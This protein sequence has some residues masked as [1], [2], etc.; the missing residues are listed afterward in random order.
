MRNQVAKPTHLNRIQWLAIGEGT[1]RACF[2]RGV[3]VHC[4]KAKFR[5][6]NRVHGS[7]DWA[8]N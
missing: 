5:G 7:Y 8:L 2:M 4:A 3:M 6:I 1:A